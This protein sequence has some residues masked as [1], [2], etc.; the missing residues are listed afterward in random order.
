MIV[1]EIWII[2]LSAVFIFVAAPIVAT[3][4]FK[5]GFNKYTALD[6]HFKKYGTAVPDDVVAAAFK[7]PI[8]VVRAA[9]EKNDDLD[10]TR[11]S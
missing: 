4:L 6:K 7:L 9:R 3:L 10:Y 1:N 11:R 5:W 8:E 2:C